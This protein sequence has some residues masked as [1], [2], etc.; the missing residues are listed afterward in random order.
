MISGYHLLRLKKQI[1]EWF[2][3]THNNTDYTII[4]GHGGGVAICQCR[5]ILGLTFPLNAG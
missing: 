3:C 5:I 1:L 4:V 2:E